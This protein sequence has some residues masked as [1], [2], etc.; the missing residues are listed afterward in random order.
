MYTQMQAIES[1]FS[2]A[3][4]EEHNWV[5]LNIAPNYEI[6]AN[7]PHY[8]RKNNVIYE[9]TRSSDNGYYSYHIVDIPESLHHRIIAR[10]F[11]DNDDPERKLVVDHK[12][13]DPTDNRIENLQWLTQSENIKKRAPYSQQQHQYLSELPP[14]VIPL[15]DYD[16]CTYSRYWICDDNLIMKLARASKRGAYKYV[17]ATPYRNGDHSMVTL[18]DDNGTKHMKGLSK[19]L[20]RVNTHA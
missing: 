4:F 7:Y 13:D 14:N 1:P 2:T 16:G 9:P 12:N 10:Q 3:T 17:N 19:I 6:D 20:N 8:I 11:V 5:T 15:G 18:Y